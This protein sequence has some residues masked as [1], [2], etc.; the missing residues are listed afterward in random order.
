MA[1]TVANV[2][3][4]PI[5]LYNWAMT[6]IKININ[7]SRLFRPW[8]LLSLKTQLFTCI[9]MLSLLETKNTT[10]EL[11]HVK[12]TSRA[13]PKKRCSPPISNWL[14]NLHKIVSSLEIWDVWGTP[15]WNNLLIFV[16]YSGNHYFE[17]DNTCLWLPNKL[18]FAIYDIW[19]SYIHNFNFHF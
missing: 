2:T 19:L 11:S 15:F 13:V 17:I 16:I 1:V 8:L 3:V 10:C 5:C 7:N 14:R 9:S 12:R 18:L 4:G 6:T